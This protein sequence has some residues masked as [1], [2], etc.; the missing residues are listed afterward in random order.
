MGKSATSLSD[1]VIA[2]ALP[3]LAAVT[4]ESAN[5]VAAV[6]TALSIPWLMFGLT[7]GALVDRID[8]RLAL[9]V[10]S[11][12][13]T[14]VFG[15][16][17]ILAVAGVLSNATLLITAL[18]TGVGLVMSE[19]ATV[20]LTPQIVA[21]HQLERANARFLTA[22]L[23]AETAAVLV[24]GTLAGF[25][26][27][28]VFITGTLCGIAGLVA[29]FRLMRVPLERS[30]TAHAAISWRGVIEGFRTLWS[31]PALRVIALMG[32]VINT[33]WTAFAATFV[34]FAIR[35][36]PMQLSPWAFSLLMT[37]SVAGGILGSVL[38]PKLLGRFGNRWGVGLNIIGNGLTYAAPV[39]FLSPWMVGFVFLICDAGSPLWKVA[40]NT[41]QQ[42]AVP[43]ELRGRVAAA[44]RVISLGAATAG[45]A[46]GLAIAN[47]VGARGLF[48]VA[49]LSCFAMLIPFLFLISHESMDG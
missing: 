37:A 30:A 2:A 19:T 44:Y 12:L 10:I 21:T 36:G 38:A 13:R 16:A 20:S 14:G 4:T 7:A 29:L 15:L 18:M 17:A 8:R 49:S 43:E 31:I 41:L 47:Q 35:P 27:V 34:L 33:A 22:E 11:L 42:R 46:I 40:T 5:L 45:P 48:A 6:T 23:I 26:G 24:A 28:A 39:L 25:G 9:I 3:I 1:F 32:A